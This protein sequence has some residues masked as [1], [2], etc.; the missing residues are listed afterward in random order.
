MGST[1]HMLLRL[2]T[3]GA[4]ALALALPAQAPARAIQEHPRLWA[5][6][7]VCDTAKHPDEI[8][9][10]A[11][12]P[13]L[14]RPAAL[15]MR[16]RVQYFARADGRWRDFT[17]D[18]RTDSRWIR[19]GRQRGGSAETGWGVRFKPPA[20]GGSYRLR[21]VVRFAWKRN[22]KV[23]AR[24]REITRGGHRSTKGA[25]PPRFSA[26]TCRIS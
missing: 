17:G 8:G 4:V 11:S 19:I 9:I 12:M 13:G 21:G 7:N 20:D 2:T 18:P 10:R 3:T 25:D 14:R 15:W 23:L 16:F 1:S 5:T 26:P 22:G 6:V 24:A